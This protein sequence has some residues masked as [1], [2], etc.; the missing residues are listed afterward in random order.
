MLKRTLVT[1]CA[2]AL[3]ISAYALEVNVKDFDAQ[4]DGKTDD[5]KAIQAAFDS[6]AKRTVTG[7]KG[8]S[9]VAFH[10]VPDVVFPV[11]TYIISDTITIKGKNIRGIGEPGIKQITEGK[12]IFYSEWAVHGAITGMT[13]CGGRTAISLGNSNINTGLYVIEKCKFRDTTGPAIHFRRN[14]N[15]TFLIVKDCLIRDCMQA[16]V[17]HTDW[18]V[19]RDCWVQTHLKMQSGA[20]FVNGHGFMTL[21]NML[22]VPLSFGV[23]QRWVDN[24]GSL[25]CYGCRFGGE[26]GGF[27]PVVNFAKFSPQAGSNW[28]L[29]ADSWISAE[30]NFKRKCAVYCEEIPNGIEITNSAIVGVPPIKVDKKIDLKT[31]FRGA[32]PGMLKYAVTDCYGEFAMDIPDLLK[33]PVIEGPEEKEQLSEEETEKALKA[34]AAA[35]TAK[36]RPA[37]EPQQYRWQVFDEKT[38]EREYKTHTEQRGPEKYIEITFTDYEWNLTD[39][40][41]ATREPNGEYIALAP[42]GDDIIIMRR[43]SGKWPHILIKN[44]TVDLDNYPF[45][46]FRIHDAKTGTPNDRGLR[47]IDRETEQMVLLTN[48]QHG[49]PYQAFNIKEK[50]GLSGVRTF[51]IRFYFLASRYR[52]PKD[53]K[54]VG[55]DIAEAGEY[56]VMDYMRFEAE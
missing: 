27:T 7:P 18:T 35:A 52:P 21:D 22:G 36:K 2:F 49:V 4:G 53:G 26:G 54:P 19:V 5:T 6:L 46:T 17:S 47:I 40:M 45:L 55:A 31:Y 42:A 20:V 38:Q 9:G 10:S 8:R 3:G 32:K 33:N 51:D 16:L 24:Y 44:V 28:I 23:D 37:R 12:D 13:F 48:K 30:S 1:V 56:I 25:H 29:I 14:S 11:G 41:D 43:M 15:S 50:M 34:A 39:Y